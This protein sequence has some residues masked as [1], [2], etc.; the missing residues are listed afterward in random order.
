MA[1]MIV[2]HQKSRL[3]AFYILHNFTTLCQYRLAQLF[4][5]VSIALFIRQLMILE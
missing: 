5:A 1:S 2:I 4:D 3:I